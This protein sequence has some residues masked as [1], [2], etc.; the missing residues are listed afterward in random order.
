MT[1]LTF[2][3]RY[4]PAYKSGGPIR[5]ISN[6][7]ACLGDEFDFRIVTSDRDSG[8]ASPFAHTQRDTW[9]RVGNAQV[10]YLSPR[11][12]SLSNLGGVLRATP[13]DL[14]YLNSFHN[15][16]FTVKPLLLRQL[17]RTPQVPVLLAPRGE[18]ACGALALKSSKKRMYRVAA[19]AL[20]L[21]RGLDWQASSEAEAQHIRHEMGHDITL[22]VGPDVYIPPP[23]P[24]RRLTRLRGSVRAVTVCRIS[25][26]KNLHALAAVL[27]H[28]RGCVT[29]DLYGVIDDAAYWAKCQETFAHLPDNVSVTYHGPIEHTQV[30]EVLAQ[31]DLFVLPTLGEN[32]CHAAAEAFAAGCPVLISDQTPW[33]GLEEAKAGWDLPLDH[34]AAFTEA[35]HRVVDMNEDEHLEWREGAR[36]YITGHPLVTGAVEANRQMFLRQVSS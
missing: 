16:D 30:P 25:P 14:L 10:M 18:L 6:L 4:L 31:S 24:V 15:P 13:H 21:Y 22:H 1:I 3:A 28:V 20:S 23:E 5:S 2:V 12:R 29:L 17:R 26:V 11:A 9:L 27:R 7:V 35:I 19:Q 36:T 34:P 33:R 32:F 8:D